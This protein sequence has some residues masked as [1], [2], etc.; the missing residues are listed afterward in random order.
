[1]KWN[2]A[3]YFQ[4]TLLNMKLNKKYVSGSICEILSAKFLQLLLAFAESQ[5]SELLCGNN[6]KI[7]KKDKEDKFQAFNFRAFIWD[8]NHLTAIWKTST[9]NNTLKLK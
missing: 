3:H 6:K 1:M 5:V 9:S 2:V 4:K 7:L 8:I